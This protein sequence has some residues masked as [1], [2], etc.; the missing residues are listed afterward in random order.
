MVQELGISV[1]EKGTGVS[2]PLSTVRKEAPRRRMIISMVLF[3]N[4]V[5]ETTWA[6]GKKSVVA[7]DSGIAPVKM[8]SHSYFRLCSVVILFLLSDNLF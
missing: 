1:A 6:P 7:K 2:V 5:P 3:I 4:Y 8:Y